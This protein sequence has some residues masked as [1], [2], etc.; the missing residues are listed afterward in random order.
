M[1]F[2]FRT[3]SEVEQAIITLLFPFPLSTTDARNLVQATDLP[4]FVKHW[5]EI[6]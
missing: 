2:V 4:K 3:H 1:D 6:L 5:E